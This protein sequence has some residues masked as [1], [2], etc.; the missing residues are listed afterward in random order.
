M[1][2][3]RRLAAV[4]LLLPLA[5]PPASAA[6]PPAGFTG[7][8]CGMVAVGSPDGIWTG[9]LHGGPVLTLDPA[10]EIEHVRCVLHDGP[11]DEADQI[12]EAP[13][14]VLLDGA[15]VVPPTVTSF[16]YDADAATL[17]YCMRMLW[18]YEFDPAVHFIEETCVE[19]TAAGP[20]RLVV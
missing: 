8:G 12:A 20:A 4:L 14:Q 1:S 6:P 10:V 18:R 5:T 19:P 13:G 9:V 16:A 11:L 3:P 17:R 2:L 15:A 7:L